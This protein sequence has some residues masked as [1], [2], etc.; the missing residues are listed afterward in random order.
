LWYLCIRLAAKPRVPTKIPVSGGGV[1]VLAPLAPLTLCNSDGHNTTTHVQT[2]NDIVC[3]NNCSVKRT[4]LVAIQYENA[5]KAFL[6]EIKSK[7]TTRY[8]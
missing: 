5:F 2:S 3:Y 4:L 1:L 7:K 8:E 6:G